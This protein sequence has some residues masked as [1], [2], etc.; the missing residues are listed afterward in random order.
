MQSRRHLLSLHREERGEDDNE[1][2]CEAI[3]DEVEISIEEVCEFDSENEESCP[4][5]Q[6]LYDYM[7]DVQNDEISSIENGKDIIC[8]DNIS[9]PSCG[10]YLVDYNEHRRT[11]HV[12]T[13][14]DNMIQ[15][16]MNKERNELAKVLIESKEVL[17]TICSGQTEENLKEE[18][19]SVCGISFAKKNLTQRINHVKNCSKKHGV[20]LED[21]RQK[22]SEINVKSYL[23]S[24]RAKQSYN[25]PDK[26]EIA[27][28]NAFDIMMNN[29]Q[30]GDLYIHFY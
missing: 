27:E 19:C 21:I 8:E 4:P 9:C 23:L 17:N 3:A 25:L 2:K 22:G 12:N 10:K 24:K 11:V 13:C 28:V 15:F 14:L 26:D 5:T 30:P 6:I 18:L 16:G 1:E 7:P 29:Q 20:R